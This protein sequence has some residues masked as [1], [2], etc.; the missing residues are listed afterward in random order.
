MMK[1]NVLVLLNSASPGI[2]QAM[3]WV[4]TYLEHF[5]V[6]CDFIDLRRQPL[7]EI[8]GSYPLIL[9]AHPGL[10]DYGIR[11]GR[12][13]LSRLRDAVRAGT[14]LVSFDPQISCWLA[15]ERSANTKLSGIAEVEIAGGDH[16][17][18]QNHPAAERIALLSE[19][20]IAHVPSGVKL[21][22]SGSQALLAAGQL[23]KGRILHWA[24]A[25][26]MHTSVL[27]PLAGLDDLFWRGL[28]WAARKPFCLRGLP[29]LITMRVDDVAGWGGLWGQS[30]LF[31]LEDASRLGLSPGWGCLSTTF[32]E[33]R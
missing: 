4:V 5:G 24:S 1:N 9:L 29:P 14:G 27:G 17:I 28:V 32:Q 31:W 13:G 19:L 12:P 10:D 22:G 26:W 25:A 20:E 21:A 23:E 33:E 8:A 11:L 2:H 7:P 30:P 15:G 16:Y 18:T 3:E 6:P